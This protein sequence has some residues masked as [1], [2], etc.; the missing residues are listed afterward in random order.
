[1][2]MLDGLVLVSLDQAVAAP[3]AAYRLG[4]AGVRVIKV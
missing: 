1:M 2:G 4:D 3:L